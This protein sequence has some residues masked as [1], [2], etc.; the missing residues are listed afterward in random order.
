MKSKTYGVCT[1]ID[2]DFEHEYQI[3]YVDRQKGRKYYKEASWNEIRCI[4]GESDCEYL[5]SSQHDESHCFRITDNE[6]RQL[7]AN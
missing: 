2:R 5:I 7:G 1:I 3:V 4:F 6:L